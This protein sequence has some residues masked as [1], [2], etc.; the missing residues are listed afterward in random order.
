LRLTAKYAFH[1]RQTRCLLITFA[2]PEETLRRN[3]AVFGWDLSGI[4]IMDFSKTMQKGLTNGEYTVFAPSEVETEPVWKRIYQALEEHAPERLVIGC[5]K[6]RLGNFQPELR[7][8][9]ITTQGLE[10]GD[11]LR[12]LRGLLT[13]VPTHDGTTAGA[14]PAGEK[15]HEK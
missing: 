2:E 11:Q 9:R 13:G 10:V 1:F 12:H 14:E 5:L 3:A 15:A 4:T 6:K 8:F 7:E